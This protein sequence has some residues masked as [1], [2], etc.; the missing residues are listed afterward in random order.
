MSDNDH[1]VGGARTLRRLGVAGAG[2]GL[3]GCSVLGPLATSALGEPPATEPPSPPATGGPGAGWPGGPPSTRPESPA[4][5]TTRGTPP[6]APV[7]PTTTRPAPTAP[8]VSPRPDTPRGRS[9]AL[10]SD[11]DCDGLDDLVMS[12]TAGP[13]RDG[14][15]AVRYSGRDEDEVLPH[16]GTGR[17][18]GVSIASGDVNGD[19]CDD[20]LVGDPTGGSPSAGAVWL[21]HGGTEG[22]LQPNGIP[23]SLTRVHQGM[24]DVPG[25]NVAGDSFGAWVAVGDVNADGFD[26]IAVSAPGKSVGRARAAG[27]VTV[28]PGGRSGL[29]TRHSRVYSQNT[30]GVAGGAETGDYFGAGLALGD[31]TGDRRADLVVGVFGENDQSGGV[32]VLPGTRGLPTGLGS[33][34]VVPQSLRIGSGGAFGWSLAVADVDGDG[35]GEVIVGAPAARVRGVDCGAVAILRGTPRGI[36]R[37]RVQVASQSSRN[38]VGV[39]RAGDAWG[40]AVAAGDIT[41]DGRAEVLVGA[42]GE[43]TGGRSESGA[44][45][46]LRGTARGL[47]GRGSVA[48]FQGA[49]NV[50]GVPE[51]SDR[52]G[53]SLS[54]SDLNGDGLRDVVVGAP[55]QRLG[56]GTE[57]RGWVGLLLSTRAGRPG[58]TSSGFSLAES[59]SSEA[60]ELQGLGLALN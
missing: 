40:H 22:L 36:T 3:L 2:L 45:T 47:V 46:V 56:E 42:P 58:A 50:P 26:D 60:R 10:R 23:V 32:H 13:D 28:V 15:V 35:R 14:R 51:D 41:G 48:V 1:T 9:A 31:V 18:F 54:L 37:L 57:P 5:T 30:P 49:R 39:C 33:T 16:D 17:E 19:G 52:F 21:F 7:R 59:S 44:Y 6:G 38:V 4:A 25:T 8:R 11:F 29:R 20:L 34:A 43:R 12:G 24:G 27:T 55:G 53:A